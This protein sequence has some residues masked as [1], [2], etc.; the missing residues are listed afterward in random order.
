MAKKA[1][2]QT[3]RSVTTAT[4]DSEISST[5]GS[6]RGIDRNF[7]PDYSYV[8]KDLKRIGLLAGFFFGVLII[9]SFFL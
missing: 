3:Q 6:S 4:P 9:L 2:R 8:I 5:P 1:K 7:N